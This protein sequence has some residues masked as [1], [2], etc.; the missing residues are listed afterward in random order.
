MATATV[1]GQAMRARAR[2]MQAEYLRDL[3]QIVDMDSPT[4]DKTAVD[5]VGRV[6][7][8]WLEVAGGIVETFPPG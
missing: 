5:A 8:G 2:T 6:V 7:R 1:D 3:E 4:D